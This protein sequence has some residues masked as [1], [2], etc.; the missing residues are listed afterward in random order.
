[1]QALELLLLSAP[2]HLARRTPH[3]ER[4]QAGRQVAEADTTKSQMLQ[5]QILQSQILQSQ[6][7]MAASAKLPASTDAHS[8]GNDKSCGSFVLGHVSAVGGRGLWAGEGEEEGE[9]GGAEGSLGIVGE[10]HVL[11][12]SSFRYSGS[13][14]YVRL[15]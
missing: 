13:R 10:W 15:V 7:P 1:M 11:Q 14:V 9:Q 5:S 6:I 3:N 12:R 4:H 8:L 2:V